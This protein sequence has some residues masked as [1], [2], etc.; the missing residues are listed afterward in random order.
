VQYIWNILGWV[1]PAVPLIKLTLGIWI[2]LPQF[3][4]EFYLYHMIVDKM[5]IV[6]RSILS[7]RCVASS[8]M[9]NFFNAI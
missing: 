5:L 3:K 7:Y 1:L 4:G 9:V 8:N 2:M 6:E